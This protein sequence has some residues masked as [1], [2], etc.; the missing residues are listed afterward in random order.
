M[1]VATGV[2]SRSPGK[3]DIRYLISD[4]WILKIMTLTGRTGMESGG[5]ADMGNAPVIGA[6]K[7]APRDAGRRVES[8]SVRANS[9]SGRLPCWR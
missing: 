8:R 2:A 1:S 4:I 5:F 3:S 6:I 9:P 7:T